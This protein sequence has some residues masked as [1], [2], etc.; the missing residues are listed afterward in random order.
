MPPVI[1]LTLS[2]TFAAVAWLWVTYRYPQVS[3]AAWI[4][5]LWLLILGSRSV[6][7]WLQMDNPETVEELMDGSPV[8]RVIFMALML[9][10]FVVVVR[11]RTKIAAAIRG[12]PWFIAFV[13]FGALSVVWSDF[14]FVAFKRWFKSLGDPLMAL[15]L[16]SEAQPA[17]AVASVLLRCAFLLLPLSIVFIKYFP[18]LGREYDSWTGAV[19]HTGVTTNKNLLGYLLLVFG[20]YCLSMLISRDRDVSR[21]TRRMDVLAPLLLLSMIVWLFGVANSQTPLITLVVGG[22]V[23][24]ASVS[25][26]VRRHF[27]T[28]VVLTLAI[29]GVLQL[30]FN[31]DDVILGAVGRD[32][33]LTGRTEIWAEAVALTVNPWIGAG[34]E[35]F[36]VGDRLRHMWEAFPVFRP[37]QAHNGYL[38]MYLN[39]GVVGLVLTLGLLGATYSTLRNRLSLGSPE[40]GGA[41]VMTLARFGIGYFVAFV[42][43]N[44]TEAVIQPLNFLFIIFVVLAMKYS[45]VPAVADAMASAA[46]FD[47]VAALGRPRPDW[48]ERRPPVAAR[49]RLIDR[50][51]NAGAR[52]THLRWE[53]RHG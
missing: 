44:V 39:L 23:A 26:I 16:V 33:T 19:Y 10:A 40:P 38:Q 42:L 8:D 28:L 9:A 36:W 49:H 2:L 27:G 46:R 30:L 43:Y 17:A 22:S 32:A 21:W 51:D 7:Q 14:P 12:N 11:R 52:R 25:R 45:T 48:R 6:S 53:T 24:I 47:R 29:G 13:V 3:R 18:G 35:S 50:P 1:A 34:F 5:L 4:P 20:L 41:E 31:L 15:V 37:N